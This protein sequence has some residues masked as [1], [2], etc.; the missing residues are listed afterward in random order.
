MSL[1][2]LPY[3]FNYCSFRIDAIN[4]IYTNYA[5]KQLKIQETFQILL[6]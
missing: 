4:H 6:F 5:L 2:G 1:Q 3:I